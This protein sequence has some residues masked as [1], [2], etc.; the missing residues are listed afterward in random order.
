MTEKRRFPRYDCKIKIHFEFYEGDPDES[1]QEISLPVKGKGVI[2]DISQCGLFII[3]NDRVGVN[4]TIRLIFNTKKH[5]YELPAR[6]VRT[7]LIKNNP[8]E[9]AQRLI[10]HVKKGDS[11]LACEF[12]SPL[13]E[14]SP[15][16]V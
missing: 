9:I 2:Y 10:N 4:Q 7:G 14:F 13:A 11:Y 3:T 16:E 8:S 6:V 12:E 15:D 1:E 5:K